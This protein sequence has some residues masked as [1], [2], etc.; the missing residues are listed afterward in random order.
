MCQHRGPWTAV[1]QWKA[2]E[3]KTDK[4]TGNEQMIKRADAPASGA[5][6]DAV[7]LCYLFRLFEVCFKSTHCSA[8]ELQCAP[9]L[10]TAAVVVALGIASSATVRLP[11][12]LAAADAAVGDALQQRQQLT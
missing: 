3:R 7:T 2:R 12:I 6:S 4:Q 9:F 1:A 11:F 8:L 10:S 5:S